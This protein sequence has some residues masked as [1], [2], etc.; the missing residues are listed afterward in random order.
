MS[1]D[2]TCGGERENTHAPTSSPVYQVALVQV[3]RHG[4]HH[5]HTQEQQSKYPT[6][7][8]KYHDSKFWGQR[9]EVGGHTLYTPLPHTLDTTSAGGASTQLRLEVCAVLDGAEEPSV[10]CPDKGE[11]EDG[12]LGTEEQAKSRELARG[13]RRA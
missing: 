5:R 6:E 13:G 4:N 8:E 2:V 7:M 9:S 3:A 11:P 12:S 1:H 10:H